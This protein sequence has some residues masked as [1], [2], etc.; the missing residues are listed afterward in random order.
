MENKPKRILI[1]YFNSQDIS[2]IAAREAMFQKVINDLVSEGK[3][4]TGY[5]MTS[6]QL[7]TEHF[8]DGSVIYFAPIAHIEVDEKFTH[9]FV[10]K[11]VISTQN[12]VDFVKKSIITRVNLDFNTDEKQINFFSLENGKLKVT[13]EGE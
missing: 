11:S 6:P 10:D 4:T 8:T 5:Q 7:R 9:I 1:T 12:G 13:T 2:S 3:K